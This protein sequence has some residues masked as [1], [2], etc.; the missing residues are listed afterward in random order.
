MHSQ[1]T[2]LKLQCLEHAYKTGHPRPVLCLPC[3][4]NATQW[5]DCTRF[6]TAFLSSRMLKNCQHINITLQDVWDTS[7]HIHTIKQNTKCN[8]L[9]FS[10]QALS[11]CTN[12]TQV[13]CVCEL[14]T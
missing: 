14:C 9:W 4:C 3:L 6:S 5:T 11:M 7:T 1:Y 12:Y 2:L 13:V 8:P 10:F